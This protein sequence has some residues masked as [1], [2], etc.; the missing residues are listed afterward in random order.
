MELNEGVVFISR[1][2]CCSIDGAKITL[3]NHLKHRWRCNHDDDE[4]CHS[5]HS[6]SRLNQRLLLQFHSNF[7]EQKVLNNN[8]YE[9]KLFF[10]FQFAITS[11]QQ[12][13]AAAEGI[14]KHK[15][16]NFT[17][18]NERVASKRER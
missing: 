13:Q 3:K 14:K 17:R 1:I 11:K 7:H 15:S 18:E 6:L 2:S 16:C 8:R 9:T 12:Q 10:P 4:L 5:I